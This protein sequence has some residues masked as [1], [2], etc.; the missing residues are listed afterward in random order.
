M[1]SGI[2]QD[3]LNYGGVIMKKIISVFVFIL[4]LFTSCTFN[5]NRDFSRYYPEGA[6]K[7]TD[8]KITFRHTN[9]YDDNEYVGMLENTKI[10]L[11]I[12]VLYGFFGASVYA[13]I[14][15]FDTKDDRYVDDDY[16]TGDFEVHDDYLVLTVTDSEVNLYKKG[17]NIVFIQQED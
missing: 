12:N 14:Y 10:I 11:C 1:D 8:G 3:G 17:T 5:L 9:G 16:I 13:R 4:V 6:W 7:S 2:I 15:D